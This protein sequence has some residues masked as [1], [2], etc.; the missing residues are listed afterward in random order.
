[1]VHHGLERGRRICKSK[2]HNHGLEKPSVRLERRLPLVSV[3]NSDVVV[4]PPDVKLR[5]EGRG[6][7]IY[8]RESVHEFSDKGE[9]GRVAYR[10]GV[11]FAI[12]LD[13]SEVAVLLF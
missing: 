2:E 10:P 12:V 6:L 5:E 8:S 3:A 13:G 1:M 11:E 4:T 9:W 7:S